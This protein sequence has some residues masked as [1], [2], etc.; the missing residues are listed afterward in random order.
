MYNLDKTP[1]NAINLTSR[2]INIV[3]N[4]ELSDRQQ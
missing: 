4:N 2:E 1:S 3:E